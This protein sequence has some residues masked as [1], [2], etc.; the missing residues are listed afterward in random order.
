[1]N[2]IWYTA[3]SVDGRIAEGSDG[4]EFLETIGRREAAHGCS[5]PT[6]CRAEGGEAIEPRAH[7]EPRSLLREAERGANT[8]LQD[9]VGVGAVGGRARELQRADEEPQEGRRFGAVHLLASP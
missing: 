8:G 7:L 5:S 6:S 2:V 9:R 3:T 4:L 1:M